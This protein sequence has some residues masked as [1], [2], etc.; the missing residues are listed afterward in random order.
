ME[1]A[2]LLGSCLKLR[3]Q[4]PM[5]SVWSLLGV[6]LLGEEGVELDVDKDREEEQTKIARRELKELG[7][8]V[9]GR[10]EEAVELAAS[11]LEQ[12]TAVESSSA[13]LP[14]LSASSPC[15]STAERATTVL[16]ARQE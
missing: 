3:L 12:R 1:Y 16:I 7:I 2:E 9:L 15:A 5:P 13:L 6:P 14:L 8:E 11:W 10:S 4:Q